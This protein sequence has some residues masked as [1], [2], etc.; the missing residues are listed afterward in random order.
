MRIN[1]L[2][3]QLCAAYI[4]FYLL[5]L[6]VAAEELNGETTLNI[7]NFPQTSLQKKIRMFEE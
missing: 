7:D 1:A 6:G 3:R 5:S 2:L 4:V